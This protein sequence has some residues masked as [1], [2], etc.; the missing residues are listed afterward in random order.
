MSDNRYEFPAEV[1]T[2]LEAMPLA[3]AAYQFVG[4][5]VVTLLVSDGMCEFEGMNR[6]NLTESFDS[7]MFDLVHPD[8]VKRL[9][10]IGYRYATEGGPYDV[11]YRSRLPESARYRTVHCVSKYM[12]MNDGSRVAFSFYTDISE[13]VK[14][15]EV[16]YAEQT[17]PLARYI[18]ED[19]DPMVVI[20]RD[21]NKILYYNKAIVSMLKPPVTYDSGM[22]FTDYFYPGTR[23]PLM[24]NINEVDMGLQQ[25]KEIRTGRNLG[26]N[27]MS[28][29]WGEKPAYIA[30]F[31]EMQDIIGKNAGEASKRARRLAFHDAIFSGVSRYD[32]YEESGYKGYWIWNLT[33]NE[34]VS[35]GIH[36]FIHQKMG[37][38]FSFDE[39]NDYMSSYAAYPED[40]E[41][42]RSLKAADLRRQYD[43]GTQ[44][45][46]RRIDLNTSGG[47]I[48][49]NYEFTMMKSADKGS[50]YLKVQ[51]EN[52]TDKAISDTVIGEIISSDYEFVAYVDI[53]ADAVRAFLGGGSGI[54]RRDR[55]GR[56]SEMAPHICGHIGI[57]QT[58]PE[59]ILKHI[60]K[61][62]MEE[63]GTYTFLNDAGRV[64]SITCRILDEE[65]QI[66]YIAGRDVTSLLAAEKANELR[67]ESA[68]NKADR[69]NEE[70]SYFIARTSHDLRTPLGAIIALSGFGTDESDDGVLNGY[71]SQIHDSGEFM[72]G[73]LND[74]LDIEKIKSG[75]IKI[76]PEV[77]DATLII[78]KIRTVVQARVS[79]K[80]LAFEID[81]SL[82]NGIQYAKIDVRRVE[83]VLLNIIVNAIK[84]T[85]KG[86]KVRW[87]G[88]K[89]VLGDG[90]PAV[91]HVISDTGVGMSKEFMEHMF[92]PYSRETNSLSVSETG[93]GL[94]LAIVKNLIDAMGGTI[95]VESEL[96]KGS[97]FTLVIPY[98]EPTEEELSEYCSS[99]EPEKEIHYDFAGRRVLVCEDNAL[100]ARIIT[101]ILESTG[102]IV[103]TAEN[104]QLGVT[105]VITGKYD[106]VLMDIMMP[107][108][109]G[110]EAAEA[111]RMHDKK[112]PIIA[113]SANA[114]ASDIQASLEAGMNAHVSKP[115]N[116]AELFSTID[117]ILEK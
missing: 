80:R 2:F 110:Y 43:E 31:Y 95:S 72:L 27:V 93:T 75:T 55:A 4:G 14:Q 105:K 66:Y 102:I 92:E 65:N 56:F 87:E 78:E 19:A 52:V 49:I 21:T 89:V 38:K 63:S 45:K 42:M 115:V 74:I 109:N 70:K 50:L 85:P 88:H 62:S 46:G 106:L 107:V 8:D 64:K 16:D 6:K 32:N 94:G 116:S 13:P 24:I 17:E 113:L 97:A 114:Y 57:S 53:K 86:G 111:I 7:S 25:V 71:F 108:M 101:K 9:A 59:E 39:L 47:R 112:L 20:E 33:D 22:T 81:D 51:E 82:T 12:T 48:T 41:F 34:L 60:R 40:A 3:I 36:T 29:M 26:V 77:I 5:K 15:G 23:D 83:Q 11:I 100:N 54:G 104:G 69:A 73:M 28:A 90:R 79:E 91:A 67:L 61:T 96:N 18:E 117:K 68:R 35:D 76:Y 1:R 37:T 30:H 99:R 103:E 10:E 84:Y 98:I 58:S 44:L